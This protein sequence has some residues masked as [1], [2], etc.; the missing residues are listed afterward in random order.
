M[1]FLKVNLNLFGKKKYPFIDDLLFC[2]KKMG[3]DEFE[4]FQCEHHSVHY[5]LI[6]QLKMGSLMKTTFQSQ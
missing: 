5:L 2:K 1:V 3:T 4:K 6:A